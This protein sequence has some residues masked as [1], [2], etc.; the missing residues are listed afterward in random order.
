MDQTL[1]TRI[2]KQLE[3]FSELLSHFKKELDS[4]YTR[5]TPINRKI[6]IILDKLRSPF[7]LWNSS[8]DK[9]L[10]HELSDLTETLRSISFTSLPDID[11]FRNNLI[12]E[13]DNL[14]RSNQ[15]STKDPE[16]SGL[17]KQLSSRQNKLNQAITESIQK[18]DERTGAAERQVERVQRYAIN[19]IRRETSEQ[20]EAHISEL[21]TIADDGLNNI[22]A[23][24]EKAS[25]RL[26]SI[27]RDATDTIIK[28]NQEDYDS[29]YNDLKNQTLDQIKQSDD[30]RADFDRKID[31]LKS[32]FDQQAI[33]LNARFDK[34]I[35]AYKKAFKE[36]IESE[37]KNYR[38]VKQL[39]KAQLDEAKEVVGT[40]SKKAL[41]HEHLKQAEREAFAYW[42]F[43][44]TGLLFLFMAIFLSVAIFGDSLGLR[45]PW[46]TWLIDFSSTSGAIQFQGSVQAVRDVMSTSIESGL[47]VEGTSSETAWFFKRISIVFLLTAPGLYLL[48]EAANH[49][50][51]ENLY[52]Q[53]GVQLASI[54]PYLK[55]LEESERNAIKKDLVKS[56]FSFHDGKA[57]T[58]NVPDFLR[59][60]KET[61]KIIRSIDRATEP[62]NSRRAFTRQ[63]KHS[64]QS[65][66][67]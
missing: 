24:V 63:P 22:N 54:T 44:V 48:K 29:L 34:E 56:F 35:D 10:L 19:E 43:Q 17:L 28:K 64:T 25:S 53:R 45:L 15:E 46:L 13:L 60:L 41:A 27:I 6:Q 39:L 30:S 1:L 61:T 40:L 58:Q 49:R 12:I 4:S 9:T 20:K 66:G 31:A 14:I 16:T 62:T 52:R 38:T 33:A 55:E 5:I 2:A 8:I 18:I 50:A 11:F 3:E 51:K 7:I 67:E 37:I 42:G 57:D 32:S 36:S 65:V 21:R 23:S 47:P 59:D 26:S